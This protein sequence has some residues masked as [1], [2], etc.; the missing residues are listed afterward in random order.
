MNQ[1][2]S[3]RRTW[4]S[5]GPSRCS[6]KPALRSLPRLVPRRTRRSSS[7]T[8]PTAKSLRSIT[9][10]KHSQPWPRRNFGRF[11]LAVWLWCVN[12]PGALVDPRSTTLSSSTTYQTAGRNSIVSTASKA[13]QTRSHDQ[14]LCLEEPVVRAPAAREAAG[15]DGVGDVAALGDGSPQQQLEKGGARPRRHGG[16]EARHDADQDGRDSGAGHR[17]NPL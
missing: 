3:S 12:E 6:S 8:A 14:R 2:S 16:S 10:A 1:A 9:A 7:G 5:R 11:G 17:L 4:P 13:A 15:Q